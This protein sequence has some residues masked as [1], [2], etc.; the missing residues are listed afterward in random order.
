MCAT[1]SAALVALTRYFN[2]DT[3]SHDARAA[4]KQGLVN[5]GVHIAQ[6]LLLGASQNSFSRFVI[7]SMISAGCDSSSD[8]FSELAT[9]HSLKE[10]H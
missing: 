7:L 6:E 10:F 8:A 5:C 9:F 2:N 1:S 3:V 4:A